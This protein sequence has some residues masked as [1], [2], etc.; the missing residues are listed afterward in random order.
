MP[1]HFTAGRTLTGEDVSF[2]KN[3][4]RSRDAWMEFYQKKELAD[5]QIIQNLKRYA[6]SLRQAL[7]VPLTGYGLQEGPAPAY[8]PDGWITSP[9]EV[10]IRLDRCLT[11]LVV[12]GYL[13]PQVGSEVEL[14][15]SVNG[16]V[17]A[18]H[19]VQPGT[20][21]VPV[22]SPLESGALLRLGI[23]SSRTYSA[24]RAGDSSDAREL[25]FV[26]Q[27]IRLLHPK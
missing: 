4:Y 17:A 10:S 25:A 8:W 11:S 12:C 18:R 15:I 3:V 26:L 5:S 14:S 1:E 2:L 9:L 19:N 23:C 16:S 6:E 20:F 24:A 27:E 21:N 7:R 22:N 13:P